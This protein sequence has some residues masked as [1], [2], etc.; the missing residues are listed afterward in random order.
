MKFVWK[1]NL[2]QLEEESDNSAS[3]ISPKQLHHLTPTNSVTSLFQ[4]TLMLNINSGK[5]AAPV[6]HD[7]QPLLLE[8]RDLFNEPHQ[9]PPSRSTDH[10]LRLLPNATQFLFDGADILILKNRR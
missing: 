5:F 2:V 1:G 3:V 6:S 8:F 7:N 4:L 9:L 10:R